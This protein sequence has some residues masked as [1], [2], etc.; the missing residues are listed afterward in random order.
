VTLTPEQFER[1]QRQCILRELGAEGQERLLA[2]KVLIVGVGGLG[3]PQALYLAAA[4]VG[5]LGLV[6]FDKVDPSNVHRQ[7]LFGPQD[8]GSLK[9]EAAREKL[10]RINPDCTIET[11]PVRLNSRNVLEILRDYDL[12]LDGTDNFAARYLINDAAV[13]SGKPNVYGSIFQFEAQISVFGVKG[14]PC[15]RCLFREP[16]QPGEVP[17]CAEAGVI[18]VL[19]G[20][21]GVLQAAEAI[22]LICGIGEPLVGR[23]LLFNALGMTW[24]ELRIARDPDCP[25]CGEMPTIKEPVDYEQHCGPTAA[26]EEVP[27]VTA[28]ELAK[29]LQEKPGEIVLVDVRTEAERKLSRIEGSL[30]IPLD[31]LAAR[32]KDLEP[33]RNKTLVFYCRHGERSARAVRLLRRWGFQAD[34]RN[35]QGGMIAWSI[36]SSGGHTGAECDK[37]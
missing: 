35:L 6:D 31:Q 13:L 4:G 28:W 32:F 24:R 18:G 14:G 9:V 22:K 3:C 5:K 10:K 33:Y 34:M 20:V 27:A 26:G 7:I 23:L 19:P 17:S 2:A 16:P 29:W 12:V 8:I 11:Y 1:Y 15:Y 30:F 21:V 36:A 25:V 37:A